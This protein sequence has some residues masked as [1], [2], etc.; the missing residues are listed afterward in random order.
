MISEVD[1]LLKEPEIDHF[2]NIKYE[3]NYYNKN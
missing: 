1:I 2:N 3:E